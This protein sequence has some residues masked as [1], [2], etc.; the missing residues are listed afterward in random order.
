MDL[1]NGHSFR[2]T[3]KNVGG[4]GFGHGYLI[5]ATRSHATTGVPTF[6]L[7]DASHSRITGQK[8]EGGCQPYFSH[9]GKWG[10]W[11]GGGGG[12]INRIDLKTRKISPIL[13]ANDPRMPKN[14][15]YLYF[16]MVSRDGRMF[17]CGASP[18]Q[19]DH[20]NADYDIFVAPMNP[21]TLEIIGEPVRYSFDRGC[22]R[23]PDVF[24][25]G[26]RRH[27]QASVSKAPKASEHASGSWPSRARASSSCSRRPTSR[28]SFPP[29][30]ATRNAVLPCVREDSARFDH[31]IAMVLSGGAFLAE[32]AG[33]DLLAECRKSNQLTV[34]AVIRPTVSISRG[35][36][37]SSPSPAI[38]AAAIS[39]S[40]SRAGQTRL[41][42]PDAQDRR[43]RRESRDDALPDLARPAG[44]CGRHLPA[45][46]DSPP[47]STARKSIAARERPG[48]L[49]AT[50]RRSICSSATNSTAIE[51]G[52]ARWKASPSTT[53]SW[54]RRS[55][56]KR[57]AVSQ[58]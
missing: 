46:G 19:H 54:A 14:R 3:K 5:N 35:R 2:V 28:I 21:K 57:R 1:S 55:P 12:P 49:L 33:D 47:I 51:T 48:K 45:Q 30:T 56:A 32:E 18:N 6:S 50:G 13:K 25:A 44:A 41:P 39:H 40:G 15:H 22:D 58:R 10:F 24:L 34:E 53:G 7:Y 17:A 42:A 20:F 38:R 27:R 36:P 52:Q 31:N 8:A 11:M 4:Q 29:P 37:G 23:F 9:D 26:S 43:E 16:P